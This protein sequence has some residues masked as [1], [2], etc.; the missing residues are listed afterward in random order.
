MF[1]EGPL[2]EVPPYY[3]F[4]H[5]CTCRISHCRRAVVQAAVDSTPVV[6]LGQVH[7]LIEG[8]TARAAIKQSLPLQE[9]LVACSLLLL[10][11][12]KTKEPSIKALRDMYIQVCRNKKLDMMSSDCFRGAIE[13]LRSRGV[14]VIK[15]PREAFLYRII[16][17]C[18]DEGELRNA[19]EDKIL[20]DSILDMSLM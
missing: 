10:V 18:M 6:T 11:S 8:G 7:R 20:I 3:I 16:S 12:R 2:S 17:L 9:R 4:I 14:L 19:V 1:S 13:R 5:C 15:K